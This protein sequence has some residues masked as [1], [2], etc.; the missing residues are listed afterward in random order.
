MRLLFLIG[1]FTGLGLSVTLF[2]VQSTIFAVHQSGLTFTPFK[3][4]QTSTEDPLAVYTLTFNC[5]A[6]SAMDIVIGSDTNTFCSSS[7]LNGTT[8]QLNA[9]LLQIPIFSNATDKMNSVIVFKLFDQNNTQLASKS[10]SFAPLFNLPVINRVSTLEV[11]Q[12]ADTTESG[13]SFAIANIDPEYCA[14]FGNSGL[15]LVS[16]PNPTTFTFKFKD[17]R[18]ILTIVDLTRLTPVGLNITLTDSITGLQT[19]TWEVLVMPQT[20]KYNALARADFWVFVIISS[21]IISCFILMLCYANSKANEY[22][23]ARTET[24]GIRYPGQD[25]PRNLSMENKPNILSESI[26]TWNQQLMAKY[27][28]KNIKPGSS[29]EQNVEKILKSPAN[30]KEEA[31]VV[32]V[33]TKEDVPARPFEDISEIGTVDFHRSMKMEPYRKDDSFFDE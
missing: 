21:V 18:A 6:P 32:Y 3:I 28:Q 31:N 30:N 29:F 1:C 10:I 4:N 13:A 16:L 25:D 20:G 22:D 17:C 26:L 33:E 27:Q 8:S 5:S 24:N 12:E 9:K 11:N 19:D 23:K 15:K 2:N 7:P 14:F